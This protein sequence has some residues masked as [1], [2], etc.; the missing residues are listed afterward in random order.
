EIGIHLVGLHA[1]QR[2][3]PHRP[4]GVVLLRHQI[5]ANQKRDSQKQENEFGFHGEV[6]SSKSL[7]ASSLRLRVWERK[8]PDRADDWESHA[9]KP[10]SEEAPDSGQRR[11]QSS[12]SMTLPR[13]VILPRLG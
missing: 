2:C 11:N 1:D 9:A 5:Q 6:L 10:H 3:A 4:F 8:A 13:V 12:A 7:T